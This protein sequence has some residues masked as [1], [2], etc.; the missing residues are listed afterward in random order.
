MKRGKRESGPCTVIS[1]G[2]GDAEGDGEGRDIILK[3]FE[4]NLKETLLY[5][6]I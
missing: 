2:V 1:G 3:G 4:I 5:K 6:V